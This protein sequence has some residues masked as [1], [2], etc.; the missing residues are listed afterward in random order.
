M[1]VV[2]FYCTSMKPSMRFNRELTVSVIK[3][4]CFFNYAV[5]QRLIQCLVLNLQALLSKLV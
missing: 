4:Q 2:F 5:L 1:S 3:M